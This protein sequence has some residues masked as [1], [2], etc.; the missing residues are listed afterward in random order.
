MTAGPLSAEQALSAG[1]A[2][3]IA[4]L[5]QTISHNWLKRTELALDDEMKRELR[6]HVAGPQAQVG[7]KK[8]A[9]EEAVETAQNE[10]PA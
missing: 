5:K 3:V 7:A 9:T 1:S 10:T 2:R 6:R 4:G 8:L